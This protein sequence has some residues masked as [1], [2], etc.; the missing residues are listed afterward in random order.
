MTIA[1]DLADCAKL[2]FSM[3]DELAAKGHKHSGFVHRF[4]ETGTL[5]PDGFASIS[6][7]VTRRDDGLASNLGGAR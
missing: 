7:W 4:G 5:G 3:I 2:D 6:Y 1:I